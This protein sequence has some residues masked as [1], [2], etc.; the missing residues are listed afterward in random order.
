MVLLQW[1]D[2]QC[3]WQNPK[4]PTLRAWL[5]AQSA[6]NLGWMNNVQTSSYF[7]LFWL[8]FA[9]FVAIFAYF[10]PKSIKNPSG[11]Y[12]SSCVPYLTQIMDK[13]IP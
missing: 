9:I 5:Q 11:V 2:P 1:V 7:G 12:S 3:S 4:P 6:V 8:V 13:N 10:Y